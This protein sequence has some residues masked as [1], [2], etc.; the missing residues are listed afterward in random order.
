MGWEI[1]Y[2]PLNHTVVRVDKL[3]LLCPLWDEPTK[4]NEETNANE[5]N[6]SALVLL[7]WDETTFL[8]MNCMCSGQTRNKSG[9]CIQSGTLSKLG[10]VLFHGVFFTNKLL[11]G[12]TGF[13]PRMKVYG[14]KEW[15]K[16]SE[17]LYG[18]HISIWITVKRITREGS[19]GTYMSVCVCSEWTRIKNV[20]ECTVVSAFHRRRNNKRVQQRSLSLHS[21]GIYGE[22]RRQTEVYNTYM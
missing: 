11:E 3:G 13:I 12:E 4:G 14:F 21:E 8:K 2:L 15:T 7:S 17:G 20:I 19:C 22:R 18:F 9:F 1:T 5:V 16:G 10:N 6:V